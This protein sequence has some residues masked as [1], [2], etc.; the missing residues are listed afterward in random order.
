MVAEA[1]RSHLGGMSK[2]L[3]LL[4]CFALVSFMAGSASASGPGPFLGY[5]ALAELRVARACEKKGCR[6]ELQVGWR[7]PTYAIVTDSP[8]GVVLTGKMELVCGDGSD[9]TV[10]LPSPA[11]AGAAATFPNPC[12]NGDVRRAGIVVESVSIPG[13]DD[14]RGASLRVFGALN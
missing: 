11:A 14:T 3:F 1:R 7:H 10:L 6:A 12:P 9:R 2:A 8:T 5:A 4:V 13:G